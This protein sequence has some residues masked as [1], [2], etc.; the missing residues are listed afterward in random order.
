MWKDEQYRSR[1]REEEESMIRDPIVM[2]DNLVLSLSDSLDLI[3][4]VVDHQRASP[5][6][7]RLGRL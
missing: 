3:T 2:L 4:R 1:R 5:T 7:L 6:S